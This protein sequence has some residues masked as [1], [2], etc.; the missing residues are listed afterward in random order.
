MMYSFPR[1]EKLSETRTRHR[2]LEYNL[3]PNRLIELAKKGVYFDD[4]IL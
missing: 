2:K 1:V 4:T 3:I